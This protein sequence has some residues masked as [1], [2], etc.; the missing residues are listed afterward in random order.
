MGPNATMAQDCDPSSYRPDGPWIPHITL[1]Q[2][3]IDEHILPDI[4]GYLCHQP[5][6]WEISVD[7]L[8]LFVEGQDG[9]YTCER[10]GFG[11]PTRSSRV[12]TG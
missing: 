1:A 11:S 10:F 12:P 4:I 7:N 6:I 8:A 2:W 9:H 3:D 5:L